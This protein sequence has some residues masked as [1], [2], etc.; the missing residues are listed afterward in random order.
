MGGLLLKERVN[1]FDF[2]RKGI[3][4]DLS[5]SESL[6]NCEIELFS[7]EVRKQIE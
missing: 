5:V 3:L 4:G 7:K 2:V 6:L 1:C